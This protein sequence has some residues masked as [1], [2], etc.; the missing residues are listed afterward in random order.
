MSKKYFGIPAYE[1][2]LDRRIKMI[3]DRNPK[4]G[5]SAIRFARYRNGMTV[6]EYIRSCEELGRPNLAVF[7]ITW[8][9]DPKRQFIELYD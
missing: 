3:A 4:R 9:S 6:G 1:G 2:P 5:A 7:D 8:D